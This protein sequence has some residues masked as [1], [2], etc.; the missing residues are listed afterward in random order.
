LTQLFASSYKVYQVTP[1]N[2]DEF[3]ILKEWE[4]VPG[5]DYGDGLQ[6]KGDSKVIVPPDVQVEYVNFLN[7]YNI[8][9][10]VLISDLEE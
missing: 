9:Y 2:F 1:A 5:I 6:R 8:S 10:K 3:D 4:Q 7:E